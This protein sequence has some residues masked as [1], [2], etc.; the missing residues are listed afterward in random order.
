MC[1]NP[2]SKP[3]PPPPPPPPPKIP[4]APTPV[5][6][7]ALQARSDQSKRQKAR[8]G[9]AGTIRTSGQGLLTDADKTQPTLLG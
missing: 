1:Q 5:D 2:F 8:T 6:P 7:A 4:P 3:K 9:L